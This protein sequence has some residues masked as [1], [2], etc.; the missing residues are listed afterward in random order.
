MSPEA[1]LTLVGFVGATAVCARRCYFT[2]RIAKEPQRT[3]RPGSARRN[4][5]HEREVQEGTSL[6]EQVCQ[7]DPDNIDANF[8][9][10]TLYDKKN[11][12][13]DAVKHFERVV[14]IDARDPRAWDYLALNME[15]LGEVDSAGKAYRNALAVNQ[16]GRRFDAFLDYNYGR[17]LMK[18]NQLKEAKEHL[19]RAVELPQTSGRFGTNAPK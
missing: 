5:S 4:S 13:A 10:G 1:T 16:R 11:R 7:I 8:E 2:P 3:C 17:F 15:I 14:A 19:D 6:L 9:L 12:H 18:G